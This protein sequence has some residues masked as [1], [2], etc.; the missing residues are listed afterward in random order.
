MEFERRVR[1]K[2]K[3]LK[4]LKE[5]DTETMHSKIL[6]CVAPHFYYGNDGKKKDK[7]K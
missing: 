7:A 2:Q 4:M 1:T 5:I 3:L 6:K